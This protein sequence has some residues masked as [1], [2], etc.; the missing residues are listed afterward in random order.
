MLI[1][2]EDLGRI[3]V[4]KKTGQKSYSGLYECSCGNTLVTKHS[5][6]NKRVFQCAECGH[7]Q[8]AA[9]IIQKSRAKIIQEFKDVHGGKYGYDKVEYTKNTNNV[10]ITCHLHGDFEQTPKAHKRGRG[11][12]RCAEDVRSIKLRSY[13]TCRPA[14][15]YYVCFNEL[16]LYK[17]GVTVSLSKRFNGE[18]HSHSI[19]FTKEYATEQQAYFVENALLTKFIEYRYTGMAL[20]RRKGNTELLTKNILTELPSSVETIEST[21]EFRTLLEASR[22]DL[23]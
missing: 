18:V 3:V 4:N 12:P 11:C 22:V 13:N 23:K 8:G 9:A 16:Y 7:R 6:A 2:L 20:L 10:T 5:V 19:L 1:L 14:C 15:L 21:E 17:I